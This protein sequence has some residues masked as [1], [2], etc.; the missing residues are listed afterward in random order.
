MTSNW[1][2]TL[3][4]TRE[5]TKCLIVTLWD[6]NSN[7]KK[8]NPSSLKLLKVNYQ[9]VLSTLKLLSESELERGAWILLGDCGTSVD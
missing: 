4:G 8:K 9:P 5:Q 7:L 6:T 3:E 1:I 2:Q